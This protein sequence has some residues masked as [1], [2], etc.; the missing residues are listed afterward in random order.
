M[1]DARPPAPPPAAGQKR[2][3]VRPQSMSA[4]P[5]V[6]SA[7]P[8]GL[9]SLLLS[10]QASTRASSLTDVL[11][12]VGG[13][14]QIS[15]NDRRIVLDRAA[16]LKAICF[17]G[18]VE[19]KN[20][21]RSPD[22]AKS[23]VTRL[24]A[25]WQPLTQELAM[26]NSRGA[27][28]VI[29]ALESSF[30]AI[31][32]SSI[33]TDVVPVALDLARRTIGHTQFDL[34]HL[35]LALL[36]SNGPEWDFLGRQPSLDE[37]EKVRIGLV[38]DIARTPE[39]KED[40]QALMAFARTKTDVPEQPIEDRV[41]AQRDEPAKLDRLGRLPFARV[42]AQRLIEVRK[43]QVAASQD[44]DRA[45]VVHLDGPWGSGKSSVLNFITEE[46]RAAD[47]PWLV[48]NVN[49]WREEARQPAWWA[50][51]IHVA[52]QTRAQV[53]GLTR[54]KLVGTWALWQARSRWAALAV[55]LVLVALSVWLF[56]ENA[57]LRDW[58]IKDIAGLITSGA[59]LFA[60]FRSITLGSNKT[61]QAL[62]QLGGDPYARLIATFG[63]LVDR[64]G[65][66]IVVVID[67]ID[68]CDAAHVVAMLEGI[69][70]TLRN[71]PI[72]YL[73]AGD[74]KWI[75]T[76]FEKT[77]AD[78]SAP[79]GSPGRS[80]GHLFLD[81]LFQLSVS[82]PRLSRDMLSRYW[83]SL[84]T[85]DTKPSAGA[86]A[87]V[88]AYAKQ[89]VA[90]IDRQEDL[91]K[92]IDFEADPMVQQAVRAAAALKIASPAAGNVLEHRFARF[93]P[94]LDH[95]PRS[96]KRLVNALGVNQ[97]ILY[98]EAREVDPD[99]LARW[100]IIEMRWPQL[101]EAIV[102]DPALLTGS[103]N[104]SP[105]LAALLA[106]CEVEQVVG[107]TGGVGKLNETVLAELFGDKSA[108][109]AKDQMA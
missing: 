27:I 89:A 76:A 36:Q 29:Q 81:K 14:A 35:V 103:G 62:D 109:A 56:P 12:W 101:A 10:G 22:A 93:A 49:A 98:L 82:V 107:G 85:T 59:A 30:K 64:A 53:R 92:A 100:T 99:V 65:A 78:F 44:D 45:F 28:N 80:L 86:H 95:N 105:E 6:V 57:R 8:T 43:A 5:A 40:I 50:V 91:Q 25:D 13:F 3:A 90:G 47:P 31:L 73:V 26:E 63:K 52:W 11:H 84:L 2:A 55:T 23:L 21:E 33:E 88:E 32:S 41:A 38:E 20:P 60:F 39:P 102:R 34:R 46:L 72:T 17:V 104:A 37:L 16:F 42:L 83:A 66:P 7:E 1:S 24:K 67:D 70:T 79:L 96:M 106:S 48:V 69:Q 68:R 75:T 51:V 77:Y 54:L 9:G 4:E 87:A 19:S 61:A 58:D 94:L 108:T 71:A 18:L 97:A 74:R 15:R